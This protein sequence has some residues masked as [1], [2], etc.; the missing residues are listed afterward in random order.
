MSATVP[1]P[2]CGNGK[3]LLKNTKKKEANLLDTAFPK[4]PFVPRAPLNK[5]LPTPDLS[6]AAGIFQGGKCPDCG[7]KGTAKDGSDLTP[8]IKAAAAEA[9]KSQKIIT[10]HEAELGPPGGNRTTM[11][12]GNETLQIGLVVNKAKSYNIVNDGAQ[13]PS[14]VHIGEKGSIAGHASSPYV[15]GTNPMSTPGGTYTIVVSN[16]MSIIVGAQGLDINTYGPINIFGGV[17]KITAPQMTIGSSSGPLNLEGNHVQITGKTVALAPTGGNKQVLVQGTLGVQSNAVVAGGMHVD[18][19]LSFT[20]GT[21]P[22]K[23][24]RTKFASNAGL[25]TGKAMWSG[26]GAM[27]AAQDFS[28]TASMFTTDPS[29]LIMTPRGQQV[30][31]QKMQALIYTSIPIEGPTGICIVPFCGVGIVYNFPH[32]H[33]IEDSVHAHEMEVPNIKLTDSDEDV[34]SMCGS[35]QQAEPHPSGSED[36]Q[37]PFKVAGVIGGIASRVV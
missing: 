6:S 10:Q 35:K 31:M 8:N 24:A 4:V 26:M 5:I 9:A 20:S 18:G 14:Q 23:I 13:A 29:M 15:H 33:Q 19:D 3:Q 32:V 17:T 11:I 36:I 34:R 1:C 37:S 30:V 27:A 22:S 2:T 25:S 16:K 7:G 28:R 12:A 21:C